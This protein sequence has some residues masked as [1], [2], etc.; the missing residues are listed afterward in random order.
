LAATVREVAPLK[1]ASPETIANLARAQAVLGGQA[2]AKLNV[3]KALMI[4]PNSAPAIELKRR[5][6]PIAAHHDGQSPIFV[7]KGS[8]E[9]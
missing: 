2:Q 1:P 3:D 7:V 4:D 6:H 5:I 8:R 9:I